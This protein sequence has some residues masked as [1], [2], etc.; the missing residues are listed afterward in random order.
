MRL[1]TILFIGLLIVTGGGHIVHS[2]QHLALPENALAAFP[3]QATDSW[4]DY[5]EASPSPFVGWPVRGRITQPFGCTPYYSG[6][7]APYCPAE[8][9]WFHDGI[10]LAVPIGQPVRAAVS[11]TVIFAGV[12]GD[13]PACGGYRGYGLGVVIDNSE[14]WQ[15][16]YAHL[17]IIFVSKGQVVTPDTVIGLSGATGCVSGPHLH[18]GLRYRGQLVDPVLHL[19]P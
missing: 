14:G 11:G 7:P 19:E 17:S 8:A 13:G 18:F 9:R 15:T 1:F 3:G 10:D 12:D 4:S 6:I 5:S 2:S 16:L